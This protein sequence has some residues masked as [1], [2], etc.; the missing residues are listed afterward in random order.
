LEEQEILIEYLNG[1]HGL[2]VEGNDWCADH[3]NTELFEYFHINFEGFSQ[4]NVV[5]TLD[6]NDINRFGLRAF[7]YLTGNNAAERPDYVTPGDGAEAIFTCNAGNIRGVYYD[8]MSQYRTYGQTVSFMSLQNNRNFDRAEF[9]RD[10]INELAGYRGTMTGVVVD[11]E[12]TPVEGALVSVFGRLSAYTDENGE[13]SIDRIPVQQFSV[14]VERRGYTTIESQDF[15]FEGNREMDVVIQMRNPVLDID[16]ISIEVDVNQN[17]EETFS[18]NINNSGD[19]PLAFSTRLRAEPVEGQLWEEVGGFDAGTITEDIRLQAAVFLNGFYWIAGGGSSAD[20]PNLLYKVNLDGEL[21][22]QFEQNTESNYGWRDMTTDGEFI[23]A[24]DAN[25]IAQIDPETGQMTDTPINSAYMPRETHVI[26][27]DPEEDIFWVAEQTGNILGI[28]RQGSWVDLVNNRNR[29]RMSGLS[30]FADDPDGYQLYISS[31]DP[32]Q[33]PIMVKCSYASEEAMDICLMP[34]GEEESMGGGEM[35][36]ELM[37]YTTLLVAQMQGRADWIRTYEAGTCFN[38]VSLP[39]GQ[40]DIDPEGAMSFDLKFDATGLVVGNT[41][42]AHIQFDHNTPVEG[43]I[44]VD[45]VMTVLD[46][47]AVNEDEAL[48]YQFGIAS[49]YPNPFNPTTTVN[50]GLDIASDVNLAVFDLSGRTMATLINGQVP[51]GLH[52]ATV[53]AQNWPSGVYVVRLADDTRVNM[54]KI[55]LI[56]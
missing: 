4:N 32:Q 11:R 23:Y 38:W 1:N 54:T 34:C 42:E 46:A 29:F 52:N 17:A 14:Q 18:V 5:R 26:T 31:L 48:P 21:V 27:Y 36:S 16:P 20:N 6:A 3:R 41:Y 19:G 55:T 8:G 33:F 13:F 56:R 7:S 44:F 40:A 9:M 49:V 24:V 28:D 50:F 30:W 2:Y 22:D 37:P 10:V 15:S 47:S 12:D 35:S 39:P 45:I 51:A 25:Y 43:A 53:D